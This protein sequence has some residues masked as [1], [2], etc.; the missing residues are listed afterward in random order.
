MN[1]LEREIEEYIVST[2]IENMTAKEVADKFFVS[3]TYL[4]KIIKRMGYASYTDLKFE[5][6]MKEI[7]DNSS[8]RERPLSNSKIIKSLNSDIYTSDV[9][10]VI[11]LDSTGLVAQYFAR[12]LMNLGQ[13]VICIT[14]LCLVEKYI[15]S[16]KITDTIVYFSNTGRRLDIHQL[17]NSRTSKYYVITKYNSRLFITA[18]NKIGFDN[19][20]TNLSNKYDQENISMLLM[21]SHALL[22][23]FKNY[24]VLKKCSKPN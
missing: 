11:G 10:F 21:L 22:S 2:N 1:K 20:V 12:Q 14:D 18:N 4:Y 7:Y 23:K 8:K 24:I 13:F 17:M 15:S 9:I 6:R 3:R 16:I 19:E 5:K